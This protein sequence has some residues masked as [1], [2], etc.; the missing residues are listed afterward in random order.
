M[1]PDNA[2]ISGASAAVWPARRGSAGMAPQAGQAAM[3][4]PADILLHIMLIT[5]TITYTN[6]DTNTNNEQ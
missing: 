1:S 6:H 2:F 3:W 5:N 4:P